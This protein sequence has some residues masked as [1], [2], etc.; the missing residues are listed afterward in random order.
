MDTKSNEDKKIIQRLLEEN[1]RLRLELSLSE[2]LLIGPIYSEPDDPVQVN[3]CKSKGHG[4]DYDDYDMDDEIDAPSL[5]QAIFS[6]IA[7]ISDEFDRVMFEEFD[8]P[9]QSAVP[10]HKNVLV[11]ISQIVNPAE[12]RSCLFS[13]PFDENENSGLDASCDSDDI[14]D[15]IPNVQLDIEMA[16]EAKSSSLDIF[17]TIDLDDDDKETKEVVKIVN[18]SQKKAPIKRFSVLKVGF[19]NVSL[20]NVVWDPD[21]LVL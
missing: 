10:N 7:Q 16:L 4:H 19:E 21:D 15:P 6:E 18:L 13:S 17:S 9:L 3:V 20:P 5:G 8:I 12:D 11:S 1:E 2:R 14:D